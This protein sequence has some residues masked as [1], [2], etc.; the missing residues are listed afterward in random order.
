MRGKVAAV[1]VSLTIVVSATTG[2][3][4]ADTDLGG[5]LRAWFAK[6]TD[7]SI[8]RLGQAVQSETEV[9]KSRLKEELQLRLAASAKE[10]EGY[11]DEQIEL[12]RQA[13]RQYADALIAGMNIDDEQDRRQIADKMQIIAD[14]AMEAMNALSSS[15]APPALRYETPE[16]PPAADADAADTI[17]APEAPSVADAVYGQSQ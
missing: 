13:I 17:E 10:L 9:Q 12:R 2:L 14:S 7:Q 3:V 11:T 1:I 6:Q 5:T 8:A 16:A 4:Y 15:Y